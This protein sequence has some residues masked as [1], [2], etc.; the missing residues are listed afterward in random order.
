VEVI[1]LENRGKISFLELK[2]EKTSKHNVTVKEAIIA[3]IGASKGYSIETRTLLYK[4]I[5]LFYKE[6]LEKVNI[7]KISFTYPEFVPYIYGPFSFRVASEL[8][9]LVY[10]GFVEKSGRK[11]NESFRLTKPGFVLYSQIENKFSEYAELN[12][13]LESLRKLRRG[14]DELGREGVMNRVKR[15]FPEYFLF[16]TRDSKKTLKASQEKN[17]DKFRK[18][19][20]IEHEHEGLIWAEL[21]KE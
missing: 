16:G 15:L 5:F 6:I 12:D 11:K 21:Y 3:V 10:A 4:E 9:N 7:Y 2:I 19:K 14:W 20:E 13:A 17:D 18:F 8:G 1:F